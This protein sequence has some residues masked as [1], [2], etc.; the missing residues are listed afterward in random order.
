MLHTVVSLPLGGQE[1][2]PLDLIGVVCRMIW[3][4]VFSL[5]GCPFSNRGVGTIGS[6]FERRLV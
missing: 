3:T 1:A 6:E 2:K 4:D 5:F